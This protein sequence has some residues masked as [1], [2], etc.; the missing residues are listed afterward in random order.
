MFKARAHSPFFPLCSLRTFQPR[1][2]ELPTPDISLFSNS[3]RHNN[4]NYLVDFV[5]KTASKNPVLMDASLKKGGT[6]RIY[7]QIGIINTISPQFEQMLHCVKLC[8]ESFLQD[9]LLGSNTKYCLRTY[10]R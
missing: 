9:V 8:K 1:T 5:Q 10:K 4:P 7:S 3:S 6:I 2:Q